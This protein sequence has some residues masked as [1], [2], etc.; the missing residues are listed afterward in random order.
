M[1]HY[2]VNERYLSWNN[3]YFGWGWILWFGLVF[4]VVY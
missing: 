2:H 1:K 4:L 3:R